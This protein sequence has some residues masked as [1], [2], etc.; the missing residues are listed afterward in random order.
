MLLAAL[1]LY[2]AIA[3]QV[4]ARTR[5]IGIR[6]ALGAPRVDLFG[7]IV[8][9]GAI[10]ALMGA[11]GGLALWLMLW[12]RLSGVL[13]LDVSPSVAIALAAVGIV[14]AVSVLAVTV[15]ALRSTRVDPATSLRQD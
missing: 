1:G 10:L 12:G 2:A 11:L 9:Q 7:T 15:P 13:N 8:R 6:L 14:L 4:G 5:E 3:W